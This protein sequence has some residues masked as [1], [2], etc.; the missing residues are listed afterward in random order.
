MPFLAYGRAVLFIDLIGCDA[1][2]NE[3]WRR[4]RSVPAPG[5]QSGW[6]PGR[7]G[8][9]TASKRSLGVAP[10]QMHQSIQARCVDEFLPPPRAS[11]MTR[12][13][14]DAPNSE[15]LLPDRPAAA[16]WTTKTAVIPQIRWRNRGRIPTRMP[17]KVPVARPKLLQ[18]MR[19]SMRRS[20]RET[21][22]KITHP[23]KE[24]RVSQW[25]CTKETRT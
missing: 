3:T 18:I 17:P 5:R 15:Q 1:A 4:L 24:G 9:G 7:G 16:L 10:H 23:T 20:P 21:R 6:C 22:H 13:W 25:R 19:P 11:Q 8:C 2:T 12:E 14:A